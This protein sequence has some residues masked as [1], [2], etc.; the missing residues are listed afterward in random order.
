M[1]YKG[2]NGFQSTLVVCVCVGG[3]IL[4][5]KLIHYKIFSDSSISNIHNSWGIIYY[6]KQYKISSLLD[7]VTHW[8]RTK[9]YIAKNHS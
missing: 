6:T 3:G 7:L 8:C 2:E 4:G 5:T 1:N 9:P